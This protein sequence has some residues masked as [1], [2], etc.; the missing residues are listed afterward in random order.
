MESRKTIITALLIR[1]AAVCLCGT[2]ALLMLWWFGV[3]LAINA[4]FVLPANSGEKQAQAAIEQL[5]E[6]GEFDES[7]IPPLCE[8]ALFAKDGSL[9]S[10]SLSGDKL[11]AVRQYYLNRTDTG[12]LYYKSVSVAQG[13]CVLQYRITTEYANAQR[14]AKLPDFQLVTFSMLIISVAVLFIA[15]TMLFARRLKRG[16][17]PLTQTVKNISEGNLQSPALKTDIKEYSA[18]LDSLEVLQNS[19]KKSLERQW[20]LEHERTE[21][22]S[23]LT[24]DLRTPFTVIDGNAQLLEETELTEEQSRYI[25]AI[26]QSCADAQGYVSKLKEIMSTEKISELDFENIGGSELSYIIR[27]DIENVCAAY[28]AR[29]VFKADIIPDAYISQQAFRRAVMNIAENAAERSVNSIVNVRCTADGERIRIIVEDSGAGFS[30][31]AL[32]HA[33]EMFFTENSARGKEGH[34]GIGLS[35]ASET[36]KKHGGS[37]TLSNNEQ[38]HGKV[39]FSV[40]CKI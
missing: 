31:S 14:R 15:A 34:S 13:V 37:V 4:G 24:H 38:G 22:L 30:K 7:L 21:Q 8:Y 25:A 20:Q 32:S 27:S 11:Y 40:C 12:G 6:K 19:L 9:I 33:C 18:V 17:A 1:Y 26:L 10:S 35:Y 23:A 36:A 28:N 5:E 16:I 39:V 3:T 2:A 29:L